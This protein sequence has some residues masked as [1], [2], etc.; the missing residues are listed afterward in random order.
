MLWNTLH[1]L[2]SQLQTHITTW[3]GTQNRWYKIFYFK[4]YPHSRFS[5]LP[6]STAHKWFSLSFHLL[7]VH[8]I[9]WIVYS[10][11]ISCVSISC[12]FSYGFFSDFNSLQWYQFLRQ[13]ALLNARLTI[14]VIFYLSPLPVATGAACYSTT[15]PFFRFCLPP[16]AFSLCST[17]C[18]LSDCPTPSPARSPSMQRMLVQSI[19]EGYSK[20][21]IQYSR[22]AFK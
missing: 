11:H 21:F 18:A 15:S 3:H 10:I 6:Q 20:Q 19:V 2:D 9:E 17:L 8:S 12:T 7:S 1:A 14:H 4:P 22:H 16:H 5:R 13:C